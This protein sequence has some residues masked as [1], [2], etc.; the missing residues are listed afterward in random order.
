MEKVSA[1]PGWSRARY[2]EARGVP[3]FKKKMLDVLHLLGSQGKEEGKEID[4]SAIDQL[5]R[6]PG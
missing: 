6:T 2:I 5:T 1:G 3:L 4:N